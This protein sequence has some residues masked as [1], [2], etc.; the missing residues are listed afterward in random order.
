LALELF[1]GF[2]KMLNL[3]WLNI[4]ENKFYL[5]FNVKNLKIKNLK[6]STV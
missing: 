2:N 4:F 3:S 5:K 1:E 6:N